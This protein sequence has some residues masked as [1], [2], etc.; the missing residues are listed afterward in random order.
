MNPHAPSGAL[1]DAEA[2]ARLAAQLRGVLLVDEAYAD[3][4]DP[5]LG[6]DLTPLLREHPNVLLLRTLSK[7][8]ALAGLRVGF[9]IGDAGLIAPVRD[10]TRDSYNLD[11]IAQTLAAA[12]CADIDYARGTWE[13]VR[14]ERRRLTQQLRALD[15]G[16][17]ASQANFVLCRL[18]DAVGALA[19]LRG[20][21]ILVRHFDTPRLRDAL[22]IT[23]GRPEE[24]DA[25]LAELAAH[26]TAQNASCN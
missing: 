15:F 19:R 3:F 4:V 16:V 26:A 18:P 25:L 11:A 1:L 24:N 20:R 2:I 9:L 23:I 21:G 17:A 14:A 10:K 13:A 12:A 7:G 22:R 6:H 8:Y 5:A